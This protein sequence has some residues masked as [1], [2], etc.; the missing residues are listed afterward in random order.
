MTAPY[1]PRR[2]V[3]YMPAANE[4]ALE[5]AKTIPCDALIL[6]L[7]D[8]VAPDAKED[9]RVAACDEFSGFSMTS[10]N[11]APRPLSPG[12]PRPAGLAPPPDRPETGPNLWY[13]APFLPET[14]AMRSTASS[15]RACWRHWPKVMPVSL[16]NR[17][18]MVFSSRPRW[19]LQSASVELSAGFFCNLRQI[20]LMR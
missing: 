10:P 17:R 13:R 8:S 7:E 1:R 15:K 20:S 6:D 5:K 4:R 18:W 9:A 16:R 11:E 12:G 19:V 14:S 3:L 2:S